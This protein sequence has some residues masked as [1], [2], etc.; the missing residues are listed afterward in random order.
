MLFL[1][2]LYQAPVLSDNLLFIHVESPAI[3]NQAA[4]VHKETTA[5]E[6]I[7]MFPAL[8]AKLLPP[9]LAGKWALD[10]HNGA[11]NRSFDG[12]DQVPARGALDGHLSSQG[13]T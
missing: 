7:P 12:H 6:H 9:V 2:A 4:L 3:I 5:N 1:V 8:E 11:G 10:V 13:R